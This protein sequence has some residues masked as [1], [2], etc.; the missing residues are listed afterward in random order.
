MGGGPVVAQWVKN[1]TSVHKDAGLMP[2]LA[3]WILYLTELWCR[4][5]MRLGSGIAVAMV[6]QMQP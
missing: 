5:Q 4:S 1:L 3:Q 6:P 2:G